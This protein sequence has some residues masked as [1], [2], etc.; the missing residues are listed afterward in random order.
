MNAVTPQATADEAKNGKYQDYVACVALHLIIPLVPLAI[1]FIYKKDLSLRSVM[2]GGAMYAFSIGVAST[3]RAVFAVC[4]L[5]G[6]F[7]SAAYGSVN[8]FDSALPLWSSLS[9]YVIVIVFVINAIERYQ[10][11]VN[12]REK[13]FNF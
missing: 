11:H 12:D 7:M 6:I 3:Q 4:L 5:I 9:F 1:E 2:L 13:F 10:R 8:D